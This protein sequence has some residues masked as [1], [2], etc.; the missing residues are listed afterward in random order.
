[1]GS[2]DV[3]V[4]SVIDV[5]VVAVDLRCTSFDVEVASSVEEE[6]S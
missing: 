1:M 4:V 5:V 6:E 2:V 3:I